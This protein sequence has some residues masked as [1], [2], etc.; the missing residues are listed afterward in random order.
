M[1][2]RE[3]GHRARRNRPTRR[4]RTTRAPRARGTKG[5]RGEETA[6]DAGREHPTA[7]VREARVWEER[8]ERNTWRRAWTTLGV[9][10]ARRRTKSAPNYPTELLVFRDGSTRLVGK[11]YDARRSRALLAADVMRALVFTPDAHLVT[12]IT[13]A[14]ARLARSV[15]YAR[16]R[17]VP[18]ARAS[19]ES[20]YRERDNPFYSSDS[21]DDSYDGE[22]YPLSSQTAPFTEPFTTAS[23]PGSWT[24]PTPTRGHPAGVPRWDAGD[25]RTPSTW[26][27]TSAHARHPPHRLHQAPPPGVQAPRL[28]PATSSCGSHLRRGAPGAPAR[29]A[30]PRQRPEPPRK[31]TPP[32]PLAWRKPHPNPNL[33]AHQ[34]TAF[35]PPPP[36]HPPPRSRPRSRVT[37]RGLW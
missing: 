9:G 8:R 34:G 12:S 13:L 6:R 10:S 28:R 5:A 16:A 27:H 35:T 18:V 25:A 32:R 3:G 4:R 11:S 22:A 30:K 1:L 26:T 31:T 21:V 15:R 37:P 33:P 29:P 36:S 7:G 23:R 20:W 19:H 24:S 14:R 17:R 2:G